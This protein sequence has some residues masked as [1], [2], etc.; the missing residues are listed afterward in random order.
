VAKVAD[1]APEGR[2][3]SHATL[4]WPVKRV[5]DRADS[6]SDPGGATVT[7][8][9][10]GGQQTAE[11]SEDL[12]HWVMSLTGCPPIT[13]TVLARCTRPVHG[14]EPATWF[15]VEADAHEGVA[16]LRCLACAD[17]RPIL[18][19]AERWSYPPAWSCHTCSQAIAEVV[20]GVSEEGGLARWLVV[21]TRCV[22]C[23][24]VR[25]LTDMV[26]PGVAADVFAATL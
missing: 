15:Y 13:R 11:T 4:G 10:V 25:G 12:A 8:R 20:F 14:D 1:N 3:A 16:R 18:D 22:E 21:S 24:Q 9:T 6:D 7:L 23:G 19:S 26:V 17:I 5:A 2:R